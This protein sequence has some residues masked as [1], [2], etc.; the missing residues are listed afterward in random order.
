MYLHSVG[1]HGELDGHVLCVAA[2]VLSL[3]HI[4]ADIALLYYSGHGHIDSVGGYLA[5]PDFTKHDY[6]V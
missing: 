2:V 1:K 6:G 4:Y 3:I 5:T